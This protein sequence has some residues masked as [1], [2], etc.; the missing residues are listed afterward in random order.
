MKEQIKKKLQRRLSIL[1]DEIARLPEA[2]RMD[3]KQLLRET[4]EQDFAI[5]EVDGN[6]GEMARCEVELALV[7]ELDEPATAG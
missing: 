6:Q 2:M 4:I 5:A 1:A 7:D 3:P